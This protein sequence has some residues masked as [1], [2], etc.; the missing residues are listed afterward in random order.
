MQLRVG[1]FTVAASPATQTISGRKA[2]FNA[3]VAGVNGFNRT[4]TVACAGGP[5]NT[6]CAISPS[7]VSLA[8][9]P[10]APKATVT[11]PVGVPRGSYVISIT[12]TSS[13]VT[14]GTTAVVTG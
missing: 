13:G 9:T 6:S 5:P 14:R 7:S 12:G 11:L 10:R 4:V 2:T 8:G 3:N 1:D